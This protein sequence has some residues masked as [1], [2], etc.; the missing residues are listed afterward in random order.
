MIAALTLLAGYRTYKPALK[1]AAGLHS[2]L[3]DAPDA[4]DQD[5]LSYFGYI[6]EI[7]KYVL[8][9]T[10]SRSSF[11][12]GVI[13]Q[14]GSG[15]TFFLKK[16]QKALK[17]DKENII[18]EFNPWRT[19]KPDAIVEEFFTGLAVHLKPF[20]HSIAPKIRDYSRRILQPG[21]EVY[22]RL[23]DTLIN[24]WLPEEDISKRYDSINSA[25]QQTG[26][27]LI[28]FID[29]L[30]RL[31]GKEVMEIL[32]IIRNTANFA[33]TFFIT[34]YDEQYI[35]QSITNTKEYAHEDRYLKKVFQLVISL[36]AFKKENL[37]RELERYLFTDDL[38]DSDRKKIEGALKKLTFDTTDIS[39]S[40][41]PAVPKE[42]I[43]EKLI[44]DIRDVKRFC[45]SFKISFHMM[46]NETDIHD[47]MVLE[48][49]R[50]S[51]PTVYNLIRSRELLDFDEKHP[52]KYK[53]SVK[54]LE[55]V[56]QGLQDAVHYLVGNE[57]YKNDRRFEVPVNFYLY[58]AYHL[59]GLISIQEFDELLKQPASEITHQFELWSK[60]LKHEE[61][62]RLTGKVM[63]GTNI[64][65]LE[66]MLEVTLRMSRNFKVWFTYAYD[67]FNNSGLTFYH[68]F[69]SDLTSFQDFSIRLLYNKAI[70]PYRKALLIRHFL[71][72]ST[73][74]TQ[75][76]FPIQPIFSREQW[77]RIMLDLL[78]EHV[79]N[80][81]EL[82]LDSL[83]FLS[84]NLDK[85]DEQEE[86]VLLPQACRIFEKKLLENDDLFAGYL[87]LMIR[88]SS[89]PYN[90][91][92]TFDPCL[93]QI[94]TNCVVFI[95]QL[96]ATK[97]VPDELKRIILENG[98]PFY[99]EARPS[100][101]LVN[102]DE[103]EFME[104]WMSKHLNIISHPKA[105]QEQSQ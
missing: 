19:S 23:L 38:K 50:N 66:K 69:K 20:N 104:D 30:D 101:I 25:I 92:L 75:D 41:Y 26:K 29:D 11:A 98:I 9:T 81:Q 56:P 51:S 32:R 8:A 59:E 3:E 79:E 100:F 54:Q 15:K 4:D 93:K 18:F 85:V 1:K 83:E 102:A 103:K 82:N 22:F 88:P 55:K 47:L 44:H 80:M 7:H 40:M 16:L 84:M 45:N 34:A 48:L 35:V 10:T 57:G 70:T 17:H 72:A 62:F 89:V 53:V 36:P 94:F 31:S 2:F 105:K 37:K 73:S 64:P 27:R 12:I 86:G 74:S 33:N 24:G 63:R 42:N 77:Q 21:K 95:K 68:V 52:E 49:I 71:E 65:L 60:E 76:N 96:R 91:D 78:R 87:R 90:G 28:V 58:F 99:K 39:G 14:W 6:G 13:A 67:F 97:Q 46:K 61:L 5:A 43:F